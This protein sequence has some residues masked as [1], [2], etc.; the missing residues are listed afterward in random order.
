MAFFTV[1][2]FIITVPLTYFG[3]YVGFTKEYHDTKKISPVRRQIPDQP[4]WLKDTFQILIGGLIIFSTIVAE[5]RYVLTSV[6]R[7]Y[8]YG[9]FGILFVNMSLLMLVIALVSVLST[10]LSLQHGNWAWWWR[11]FSIGYSAGI[12]LMIFCVYSMFFD[13]G[14]DL[15]WSDIVYLLYTVLFGSMFGTMCGAFSLITSFFFVKIIYSTI[16]SD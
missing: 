14:M 4:Y 13:F 3:A 7:S 12:F 5:F 16:K 1:L 8:I 11:S 9:M 10:Y 2:W 15:F 6:W